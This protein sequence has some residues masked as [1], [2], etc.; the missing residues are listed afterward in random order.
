MLTAASSANVL[1]LTHPQVAI[2][3][4]IP[5]PDWTLSQLG[6]SRMV[7]FAASPWWGA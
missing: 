5:V 7:R 2:D 6:A 1:F 4:A 3:P